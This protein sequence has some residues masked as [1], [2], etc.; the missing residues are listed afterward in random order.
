M[1]LSKS[2]DDQKTE[3]NTYPKYILKISRLLCQSLF[4]IRSLLILT[5]SRL[6]VNDESE[7]RLY[8]EAEPEDRLYVGAEL[9]QTVFGP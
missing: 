4:Y 7:D 6:N 1:I 3:H 8:D 2:E 5:N 9:I